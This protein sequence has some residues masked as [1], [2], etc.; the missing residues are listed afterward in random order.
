[1]RLSSLVRDHKPS[2]RKL[3]VARKRMAASYSGKGAKRKPLLVKKMGKKYKVIDGNT[4]V[5]ALRRMGR[6]TAI[7]EVKE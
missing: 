3:A 2:K 1:M 4:T 5:T 6:K 7:V